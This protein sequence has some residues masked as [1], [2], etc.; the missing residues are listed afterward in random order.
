LDIGSQYRSAIYVH[1]ADQAQASASL[2][3]HQK[4]LRKGQ[5]WAACTVTLRQ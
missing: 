4:Q 3:K 1:D 2:A 5:G